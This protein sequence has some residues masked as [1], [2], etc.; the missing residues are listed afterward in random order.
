MLF[1]K[2][3]F[4]NKRILV[5][6]IFLLISWNTFC[7]FNTY[8]PFPKYYAAWGQQEHYPPGTPY[9]K[10]YNYYLAGDTVFNG[11]V[12]KKVFRADSVSDSLYAAI[13]EDNNKRIYLHWGKSGGS[14]DTLLYDFNLTVGINM[15][16]TYLYGSNTKVLSC[17]SILIGTAYRKE[18]Y[19]I[20]NSPTGPG[21]D[22]I[23]GIGGTD[24]LFEFVHTPIG[25]PF[26]LDCF[27]QNGINLYNF[28]GST[29]KCPIYKVDSLSG[30]GTISADQTALSVYPNPAKDQI[31]L[32]GFQPSSKESDVRIFSPLGQ[33]IYESHIITF[34]DHL[35]INVSDFAPGL[36]A[37]LVSNGAKQKTKKMLIIR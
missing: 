25:C 21:L 26:N 11:T 14:Q 23:E 16:P 4:M 5:L 18:F 32:S 33:L 36:Y 12:Y 24:G 1:R 29:G 19:I 22:I 31:T 17:D 6:S 20:P 35:T 10:Y 15:P 34:I 30:I 7:Q 13:R 8:H 37:I 3:L 2:P 28:N 9:F 27:Q